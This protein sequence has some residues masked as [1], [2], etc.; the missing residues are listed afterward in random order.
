M[1]NKKFKKIVAAVLVACSVVGVSGAVSLSQNETYSYEWKKT[2]TKHG[3]PL[4]NGHKYYFFKS[5]DEFK[6]KNLPKSKGGQYINKYKKPFS[7]AEIRAYRKEGIFA[8]NDTSCKDE[9]KELKKARTKNNFS[10][11]VE[12]DCDLGTYTFVA[13]YGAQ[14]YGHTASGLS[15]MIADFPYP[16]DR[17]RIQGLMDLKK[18]GALKKYSLYYGAEKL[19]DKQIKVGEAIVNRPSNMPKTTFLNKKGIIIGQKWSAATPVYKDGKI[20]SKKKGS[21]VISIDTKTGKVTGLKKGRAVITVQYAER[22]GIGCHWVDDWEEAKE[23]EMLWYGSMLKDD[24]GHLHTREE[25]EEMDKKAWKDFVE[26]RKPDIVFS[27]SYVI[28]V[29]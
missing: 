22:V 21:D 4:Y 2:Y 11:L 8:R 28:T 16:C 29:K 25:C 9:L 27:R 20:I 6:L 26:C 24:K 1:H 15:H 5:I 17:Y 12:F 23:E 19:K 14:G 18:S 7:K 13:K 10:R 3:Y